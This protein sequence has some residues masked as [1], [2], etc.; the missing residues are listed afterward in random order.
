MLKQFVKPCAQHLLY[1]Y[2]Y[3]D[4]SLL[5]S[6]TF[7]AAMIQFSQWDHSIWIVFYLTLCIMYEPVYS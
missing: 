2:L 1:S 7:G 5:Y 4:F 3:S 6:I